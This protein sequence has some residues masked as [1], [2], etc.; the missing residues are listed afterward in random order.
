MDFL[1][2]LLPVGMFGVIFVAGIIGIIVGSAV[3]FRSG[4]TVVFFG[5]SFAASATVALASQG[6][7]LGWIF[8]GISA[9]LFGVV[10]RKAYD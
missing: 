7:I 6:S 1:A 3:S 9:L 4:I 2:F 10:L 8:A 5:F